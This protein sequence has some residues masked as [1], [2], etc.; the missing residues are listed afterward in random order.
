M[1][2]NPDPLRL[3]P[4]QRHD[5]IVN[6]DD[7]SLIRLVELELGASGAEESS[8]DVVYL[9]IRKTIIFGQSEAHFAWLWLRGFT[10]FPDNAA[11]PSKKGQSCDSSPESR[12]PASAPG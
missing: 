1:E 11:I 12:C 5:Q 2:Y 9:T 7:I 8:D 4:R 3:Q 6:W 10:S